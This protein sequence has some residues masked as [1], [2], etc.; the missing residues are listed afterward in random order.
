MALGVAGCRRTGHGRFV[1]TRLSAVWE[2]LCDGLTVLGVMLGLV[3]WTENGHEKH[4]RP[5]LR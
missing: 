3:G 5:S 2:R 1:V 4:G